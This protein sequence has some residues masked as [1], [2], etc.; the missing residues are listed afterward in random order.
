M[1]RVARPKKRGTPKRR[2]S[3]PASKARK[4][5]KPKPKPKAKLSPGE[6]AKLILR[7]VSK[8][9]GLKSKGKVKA[10]AKVRGK[11]S[12]ARVQG[13]AR[14]RELAGKAPGEGVKRALGGKKHLANVRVKIGRD[15]VSASS[16]TRDPDRLVFALPKRVREILMGVE[17]PKARRKILAWARKKYGAQA[18]EAPIV[19]G[20]E[21]Y[22]MKDDPRL[23]KK[24]ARARARRSEEAAA[25][26]AQIAVSKRRLKS[27]RL[28]KS[29]LTGRVKRRK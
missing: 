25:T 26:R 6:R 23:A 3:P 22:V 27:E 19:R 8:R 24:R 12:I 7:E 2:A 18:L 13:R 15:W 21:V 4:R 28:T 5:P 29:E 1:L 17:S 20:V 10:Q 14:L 11:S 16:L 9:L